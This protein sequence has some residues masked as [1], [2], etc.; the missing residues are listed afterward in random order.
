MSGSVAILENAP[1]FTSN[2]RQK[3]RDRTLFFRYLVIINLMLGA[4]YI[5]WRMAQSL[6]WISPWLSI[7]LLLAELYMYCGGVLFL[8]DLWRSIE[9]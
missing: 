6:N 5:L 7:S 1:S 8:I 4:W 3:L 9:L 2:L